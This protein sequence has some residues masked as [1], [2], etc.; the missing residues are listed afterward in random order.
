MLST[1]EYSIPSDPTA[2]LGPLTYT[3]IVEV[4]ICG[5]SKTNLW[6][7]EPS[8]VKFLLRNVPSLIKIF[9]NDATKVPGEGSDIGAEMSSDVENTYEVLFAS[10]THTKPALIVAVGVKFSEV[11]FRPTSNDTSAVAA[12]LERGT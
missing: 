10:P 12:V 4:S 6:S 9:L 7:N 2:S 3:F 8:T 1:R 5:L 11:M